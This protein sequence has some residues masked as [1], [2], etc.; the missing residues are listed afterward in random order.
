MGNEEIG[1][2]LVF[3]FQEQAE[4]FYQQ[5]SSSPAATGCR[6]SILRDKLLSIGRTFQIMRGK[7]VIERKHG[8][9][10]SP[11]GIPRMRLVGDVQ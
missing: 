6:Q 5:T 11:S 1:A 7:K 8:P 4:G 10:A 3:Q 9:A 2:H